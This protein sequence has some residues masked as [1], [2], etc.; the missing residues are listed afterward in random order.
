LNWFKE[1]D[2]KT[3]SGSE[4]HVLKDFRPL[5]RQIPPLRQPEKSSRHQNLRAPLLLN[6]FPRFTVMKTFFE[7]EAVASKWWIP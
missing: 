1:V 7:A 4:F 5:S 6:L 2:D 3:Y